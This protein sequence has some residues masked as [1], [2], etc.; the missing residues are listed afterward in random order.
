MCRLRR[1][2]RRRR[3]RRRRDVV[4]VAFFAIVASIAALSV[5]FWAHG[6]LVI[7]YCGNTNLPHQFDRGPLLRGGG[8]N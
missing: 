3:N 6:P 5:P 1:L 8:G 4:V 7:T 2:R